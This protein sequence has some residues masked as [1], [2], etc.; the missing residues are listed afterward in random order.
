MIMI[1]W[2][3]SLTVIFWLEFTYSNLTP[4]LKGFQ[5]QIWT[6]VK[7]LEKKLPSKTNFSTSLQILVKTVLKV[8]KLPKLPNK[9][10]LKAHGAS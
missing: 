10:S 3:F 5:Y 4:N 7:R 1:V 9:S 2:K 6:S 8:L